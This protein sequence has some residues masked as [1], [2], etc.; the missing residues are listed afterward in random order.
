MINFDN[1][2]LC[3]GLESKKETGDYSLNSYIAPPLL[4]A[5]GQLRSDVI[6]ANTNQSCF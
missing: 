2:L 1:D 6:S 5:R 4:Y 3:S